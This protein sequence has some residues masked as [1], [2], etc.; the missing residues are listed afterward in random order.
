MA[1][2]STPEETD[3]IE[4]MNRIRNASEQ[5]VAQFHHEVERL[6]DWREHVRAQPLLA[7]GA[8]FVVGYIAVNK[9]TGPRKG[10]L[11]VRYDSRQ[12]GADGNGADGN[13]ADSNG[14]DSKVAEVTAS[15]SFSAGAMALFGSLASSAVRMAATHYLRNML[16]R[17]S[18]R[19]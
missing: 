12:S 16:D 17:R 11:K 10:S 13:G 19:H 4:R 3:L 9:L 6:K 18:D 1:S 8:S 2:V 14:A 5:H 15:P 7:I